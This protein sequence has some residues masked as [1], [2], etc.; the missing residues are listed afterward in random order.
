MVRTAPL[1]GWR[2]K[3]RQLSIEGTMT[4]ANTNS[5][6]MLLGCRN[7]IGDNNLAGLGHVKACVRSNLFKH[8]LHICSNLNKHIIY[9]MDK[10]VYKLSAV[11]RLYPDGTSDNLP[12]SIEL[13]DL[14]AAFFNRLRSSTR[15]YLW[16]CTFFH[17]HRDGSNLPL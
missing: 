13:F 17:S 8:A 3:I 14:S 1:S 5:R 2:I 15:S 16:S 7:G 9:T 10:Q 6:V 11:C 12:A 4:R